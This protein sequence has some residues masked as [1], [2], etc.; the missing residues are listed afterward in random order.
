M[1]RYSI[2][3][4]L[5]MAITPLTAQA[6]GV[7]SDC[8]LGDRT[9]RIQLPEGHTGKSPIGAIVFAHGYKGSAKGTMR[10]ASLLALA[11]RLGVALV[12][13]KS[14]KDDWSIPNAPSHSTDQSVDEI[15]YF[16]ALRAHLKK[17]HNIQPGQTVVSGFSAGGM[18]VW[19]L[20]CERPQ[21]YA[22][23]VPMAGT[24]WAPVPPTC[25]APV[26]NLIHIHGTSDKIVPLAGRPIGNTRQGDVNKAIALYQRLGQHKA[27]D[28]P[29]ID[30]NLT[31]KAWKTPND[32]E[33]VKCLHPGGHGFRA[34]YLEGAWFN[35]IGKGS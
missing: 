7:N 25:N 1:L 34:S 2:I 5:F 4:G 18:M 31:C 8:K 16:D 19:N 29:Q 15:A 9:Y 13:V 17:R 26:A 20:A 22:G 24:F 6:C 35:L 3:I 10:N 33:L 21:A 14:A 23:F 27:T 30:D 12:A 28:A 32:T 11:N